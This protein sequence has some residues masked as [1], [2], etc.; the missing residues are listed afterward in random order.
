MA[1]MRLLMNYFAKFDGKVTWNEVAPAAE[2]LYHP[3]MVVTT[4]K[5][6]MK[7]EDFK[8]AVK[9]TIENGL[10]IETLK[11]EKVTNGIRYDIIFHKPDGTSEHAK[12]LG[13]FKDGQLYR[14]KPDTP[15]VY[16]NVLEE[17]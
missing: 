15:A 7:R 6:E 12:T 3:E 9:T 8:E 16:T 1:E 11:M 2:R 10:S 5:G 17:E 14:V 13:E 4:A